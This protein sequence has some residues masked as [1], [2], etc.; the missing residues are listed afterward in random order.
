[1][2]SKTTNF[3][4]KEYP[5]EPTLPPKLYTEPDKS[6]CNLKTYLPVE[7]TVNPP[8]KSGLELEM[9][10]A[11]AR[12]N[13]KRLPDTPLEG[14]ISQSSS[15]QDD[16]GEI[17]DPSEAMDENCIENADLRELNRSVLNSDAE[18]SQ[19]SNSFRNVANNN[20]STPPVKRPRGRPR[21]QPL[22]NT[23]TPSGSQTVENESEICENT[24]PNTAEKRK[25]QAEN[26]SQ[27]GS[28]SEPPKRQKN[29]EDNSE[30]MRAKYQ[31]YWDKHCSTRLQTKLVEASKN[32]PNACSQN[33][34]KSNKSEEQGTR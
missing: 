7:L 33:N 3:V 14:N 32:S 26:D 10:F 30:E 23:P 20:V 11:N 16:E 15:Q 19:S 5:V 8:K 6:Y 24:P 13:A 28:E 2:I 29:D 17:D 22:A 12:S 27:S 1:M 31:Q 25:T 18:D 9:L 4:V 34:D 21:R